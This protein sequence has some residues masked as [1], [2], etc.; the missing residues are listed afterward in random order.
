MEAEFVQWLTRRL[1]P[2]ADLL[3]GIGDDAAVYQV[4][5]DGD[6]RSPAQVVTTDLLCDG[7]HFKYEET[8]PRA[9]GRKAL[10]VNLSDLAA[11][12]ARPR[13]AVVSLLWPRGEPMSAAQELYEG[14]IELADQFD[15]AIAGGDTNRWHGRLVISV[16]LI[17][18][19]DSRGV[20]RRSG[21]RAGDD[22]L[23]TGRLGGSLAGHHLD[24]TPRI[25]E[26]RRLHER[27]ELHAGMDI[28][29]GLL[30][31]LSRLA[32]ASGVGAELDL[33]A[34]P[35]SDAA[36]ALSRHDGRAPRDHALQDG[37]D[38]ELLLA[39]APET[40]ARMLAERP[41]ECELTRI[42]SVIATPGLWHRDRQGQLHPLTPKG[43]LH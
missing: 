14:L 37:E 18:E 16:T 42:G 31:D 13:L 34:V 21:A 12:A 15:V 25:N 29:D 2:R 4:Q 27:Y 11:M 41:L 23:V 6:G 1:T 36:S 7:V 39:V 33:E 26:A 10:A 3:C 22:I 9:I 17:G 35:V 19:A 5:P 20:L 30:L 38:F 28:S 32:Q 40:A 8:P 43:Y 24:F